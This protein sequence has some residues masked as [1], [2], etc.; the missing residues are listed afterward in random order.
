MP[1]DGVGEPAWRPNRPQQQQQAWS[2]SFA[3]VCIIGVL[4]LCIAI[5]GCLV[6]MERL[7]VP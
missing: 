7:C 4:M 6:L 2:T 1:F 5:V 3:E